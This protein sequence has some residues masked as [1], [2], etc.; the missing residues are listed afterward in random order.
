M[1]DL[2]ISQLSCTWVS[3][4]LEAEATRF[5][6]RWIGLARLANPAPLYL[7]KAKGGLGLPSLI[8]LWKQQQ[9]SRV[10]QF[11]SSR[12]PVVRCIATQLTIKD[13]QKTRV[14]LKPMVVAR[15]ALVTDP[16]MGRRKLSKVARSMVSE[17]ES[18]NR[19]A[20]MMSAEWRSEA[21][22]TVE[23]EA[24][25]EWA[26]ALERLSPF[27]L[28]FALNASQ[29]TLP[30]NANLALWKGHPSE[31]KLCGETQTLLHVLCSCPVALQLRR[32]NVRHDQVLRVIFNFLTEHLPPAH[33]II[34]DL[35]DEPLFTFPPHIASTDLRPDIVI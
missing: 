32:F 9:V 27:Q 31:C 14:K 18:A 19:F 24:A 4:T 6:K 1:W 33:S 3:T 5:L 15:E 29:D 34:A 25:A 28:K 10:C 21:L 26:S 8:S 17:D 30:H 35:H 22:R 20:T 12:D 2:T 11:I 7:P 16:G 23:E 13:E